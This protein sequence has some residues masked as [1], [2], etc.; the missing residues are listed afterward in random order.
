MLEKTPNRA[1]A[2]ENAARTLVD[3]AQEFSRAV[4]LSPQATKTMVDLAQELSRAGEAW[5]QA[6]KAL[7][8][9]CW[10]E[11]TGRRLRELMEMAK[12]SDQMLARHRALMD[13]WD[14][15]GKRGRRRQT[16]MRD[17]II[18]G[19]VATAAYATRFPPTRSH[20]TSEPAG[21]SAC[22]IVKAALA[23]AGVCMSERTIEGIWDRH[24]D[25]F[26]RP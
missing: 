13:R 25:R 1:P 2:P 21:A 18:A 17:L 24:K 10:I 4:Q 19:Q 15:L 12:D 6:V 3:V 9:E 26:P 8:A 23:Q 22:S 14:G 11:V 7:R 16:E 20:A 5:P